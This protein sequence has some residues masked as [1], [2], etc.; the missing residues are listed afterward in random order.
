MRLLYIIAQLLDHR[1]DFFL[2]NALIW[3]DCSWTRNQNHLVRKRTL[4]WPVWPNGWVFVNE[5]SGFGFESSCSHLNFR[6]STCF[7]QVVSWHS[8]NYRVWIHTE[9]R[10]SHDKNIKSLLWRQTKLT[11]TYVK[12]FFIV[13]SGRIGAKNVPFFF[14]CYATQGKYFWYGVINMLINTF[15]TFVNN[16]S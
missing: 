15:S 9:T 12:S 2:D 16:T 10:T 4:N 13:I 6:F 11:N 14:I 5:L 8:G 7:V 1:C 3:S